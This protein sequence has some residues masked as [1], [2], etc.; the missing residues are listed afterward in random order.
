MT[1][2][3]LEEAAEIANMI[4][5]RRGR[6]P[7][8]ELETSVMMVLLNCGESSV[9]VG[10]TGSERWTGAKGEL[11]PREGIPLCPNG[12]SLVEMGGGHR[13]ALVPR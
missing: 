12:H 3:S 5:M 6:F 10:C 9:R 13:L 2:L 11:T 7:D 4:Q 1:H 8:E